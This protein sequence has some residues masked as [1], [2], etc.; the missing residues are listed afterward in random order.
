MKKLR[1]ILGIV[2]IISLLFAGLAPL[3]HHALVREGTL[4]ASVTRTGSHLLKVV[5]QPKVGSIGG[6]WAVLGLARGEHPV[7]QEYWDRYYA[8]VE[9]YVVARKGNLHDKKYTEYSRLVVA[10]TS[11]G[12]D[13]RNVGGY[14]LLT[15]LGD[16]DKTIWQ[17]LNGPIWAL[18]ALDSG[19]YEMPKNPSAKTQATRQMYVD[20][21]L[22]LQLEDGGWSLYGGTRI[23]TDGDK[24]ADADITGM[25]L[26]A[27]AKY[28][29]QEN[30]RKAAARA[31]E[32]LSAIQ[33]EEGGYAS[34][35]I[36]NLESAVQVLVALGELGISM[37]DPRFVKNGKT[38][39]DNIMTYCREDGSFLHIY[40]GQGSNQMATEQ[41]YY[42]LVAA[43]RL[44]KG[45][46]SLYR[47]NDVKVRVSG[48]EV[49]NTVYLHPDVK[50]LR[51]VHPDVAFVDVRL[52]ENREAIE[53]LAS[54][55]VLQGV[56]NGRFAPERTMTR[57]E[58]ATVVVRG[59]GLKE[60]ETTAFSDV[61]S[62]HWFNRFVGAAHFYGLVEGT[63]N[64]KFTPNGWI[65]KEQAAT[66]LMRASKLCGIA[67]EMT[68]SEIRDALA[69]FADYTTTSGWAREALA[70]CYEE[71]IFDASELQIE[72]K[73]PVLRSEIAQMLYNMLKRAKLLP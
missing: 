21:I 63:G 4:D 26:Q 37:E 19:S 15:A 54:R 28:M 17:G 20:R 50:R 51:V 5:S 12:A 1:H 64:G 11:I 7:P 52:H 70:F 41:G 29:D 57:A 9:E 48:T 34:R 65:T 27:L 18:I 45:R 46:S 60:K 32:C 10:L 6:E 2:L 40:N 25:A 73:R 22:E 71:G 24:K 38:L 55:A 8:A 49:P 31:L 56:G 59:L 13:P 16:Y 42:G 67:R 69:S 14:N 66:L 43:Q 23:A 3:P 33:T 36:D 72:P 44:R 68:K 62:H 35:G 47:M 39:L 30:V 58:F 53:S 61:G